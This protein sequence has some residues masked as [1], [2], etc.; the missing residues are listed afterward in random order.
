MKKIQNILKYTCLLLLMVL[1]WGDDLFASQIEDPVIIAAGEMIAQDSSLMTIKGKVVDEHDET[2]PGVTVRIKGTSLGTATD[3][4]G[5]FK[6]TVSPGKYVLVFTFVGYKKRELSSDS[7][8]LSKVILEE[9]MKAI[10]EV[11]VTGYQRIDRKLF[12]GAAAVV[13]AENLESDGANDVARN[14]VQGTE[15]HR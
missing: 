5:D 1:P 9:D 6:L 10:E 13:R 12:T 11:V 3:A 8:L 2:L 15:R 4:Q 14:V 7:K